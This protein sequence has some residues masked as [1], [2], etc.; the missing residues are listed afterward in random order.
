MIAY[1]NGV[2][3]INQSE[4]QQGKIANRLCERGKRRL[5]RDNAA[6]AVKSRF[7]STRRQERS[8]PAA[9]CQHIVVVR[10]AR[11]RIDESSLSVHNSRSWIE[12]RHLSAKRKKLVNSRPWRQTTITRTATNTRRLCCIPILRPDFQAVFWEI[13]NISWH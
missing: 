3:Y 4:K 5:G 10:H 8:A 6:A 12:R 7:S 2:C 13:H 1:T 11:N 9:W